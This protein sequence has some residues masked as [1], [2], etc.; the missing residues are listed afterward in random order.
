MAHQRSTAAKRQREVKLA[1][2]RQEKAARRAQIKEGRGEAQ[3]SPQA[4][5]PDIADIVPG[6]QPTPSW[7]AEE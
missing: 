3:P 1:E 2:P 4:V 6:P 5:D 7:M